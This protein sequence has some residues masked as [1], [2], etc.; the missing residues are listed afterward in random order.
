MSTSTAEITPDVRVD[1]HIALPY[2]ELL[3]ALTTLRL[4]VP[5]N[6]YIDALG[7]VL[8]RITDGIATLATC[9]LDN[10]IQLSLAEGITGPDTTV[11]LDHAE[12]GRLLPALTKGVAKAKAAVLDATLHLS[13]EDAELELN[14][15]TTPVRVLNIEDYP[16]LPVA[17]AP[18]YSLPLGALV[19]AVGRVKVARGHDD[20]LPMLTGIYLALDA[21]LAEL[22]ATDRY[23][24]TRARVPVRPLDPEADPIAALLPGTLLDKLAARLGKQGLPEDTSVLIGAAGERVS[25]QVGDLTVVLRPL[26]AQFP[27]YQSLLPTTAAATLTADRKALLLAVQRAE[28]LIKAKAKEPYLVAKLGFT[29]GALTVRPKLET[30]E[31]TAPAIAAETVDVQHLYWAEIGF[32][33]SYLADA[34]G[35]FDAERVTLHLNSSN[36]KPVLFT[37]AGESLS[38]DYVH[39][40]MPQRESAG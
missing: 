31:V 27:K 5:R 37:A 32:S 28:A 2:P 10:S 3:E 21:E 40:L 29:D 23:R 34:L 12:L 25:L 9:D 24:L 35:N 36:L 26:D 13:G 6:I 33:F 14:G 11:L 22:A 38:G 8:I 15:Y 4:S 17:P 1:T 7:G 18:T 19:Q 30:G 20:T 16:Q 39:L